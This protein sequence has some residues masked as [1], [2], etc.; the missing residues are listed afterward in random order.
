M[1]QPTPRAKPR[2]RWM[3]IVVIAVLA[4]SALYVGRLRLSHIPDR[5]IGHAPTAP[6]VGV[7][8]TKT[9]EYRVTG[10]A[11]ARATVSYLVPGSGV[12]DEQVTLP[13]RTTLTT[14]DFTVA[15]GVLAQVHATGDASC[16]IRVNG[17]DRDVERNG[18]SEPVVNCAV[19][20]A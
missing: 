12:T 16:A 3:M 11:G 1:Q 2:T 14:Q 18:N 6:Q 17:T 15:V 10:P 9:I 13:W 8:R 5:A 4:V 20:T 19:P 7:P